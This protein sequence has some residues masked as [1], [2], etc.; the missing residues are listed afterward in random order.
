M[1]ASLRVTFLG[2]AEA[3]RRQMEAEARLRVTQTS[4]GVGSWEWDVQNDILNLSTTAR[5]NI[6]VPPEGPIQLSSLMELVH[7]DD[8]PMVNGKDPRGHQESGPHY[9]VEYR[10][11]GHPDG[12]RWIHGQGQVI[13]DEAGR[14]LHVV[15]VNYDVTT[16][17]RGRREAAR[18]RGPLPRPGLTAPRP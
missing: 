7:P 1:A 4:S 2:L 18:E 9:E 13:R 17:R 5:C 6:G 8:R 10:L 12:E 15:G 16:R 3:R 14:A 11:V